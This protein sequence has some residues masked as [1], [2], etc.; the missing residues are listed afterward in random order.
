MS[1]SI[2]AK[3]RVPQ[4][5]SHLSLERNLGGSDSHASWNHQS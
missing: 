1:I 2:E 4:K 3:S 5:G